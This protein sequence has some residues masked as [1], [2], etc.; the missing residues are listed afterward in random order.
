MKELNFHGGKSAN[1]SASV[2]ELSNNN[3]LRQGIFK[4]VFAHETDPDKIADK[5]F[6]LV[7]SHSHSG[8]FFQSNDYRFIVDLAFSTGNI[9]LW[10]HFMALHR[11]YQAEHRP[12]ELRRHMRTQAR[13]KPEFMR[14]WVKRNRST[15]NNYNLNNYRIRRSKQLK[16]KDKKQAENRRKNLKYIKENQEVVRDGTHWGF[17]E[18]FAQSLLFNPDQIEAQFGDITLVRTALRNCLNFIEPEIPSLKELAELECDSKHKHVETILYA[19]C[20]ETLKNHGNLENVKPFMLAALLTNLDMHYRAVSNEDRT[21]LKTEVERLLFTTVKEVENF[22]NEYIEPQLSIVGCK[23][24]QVSW[25]RYQEIF[26]PFQKTLPIEWLK[27]FKNLSLHTQGELV[28]MAAQ[29]GNHRELEEIIDIRCAEIMSDYPEKTDNEEI[30]NLRDFWLI[31]AFYFLPNI[32]DTYWNWL[33]KD[34]NTIFTL[35]GKTGRFGGSDPNWPTLSAQK[36]EAI[37]DA[38]IDVWSKVELPSTYGTDSPAEER[39]YRF[40]SDVIW[41]IGEDD[42]DNSLPALDRL[43]SDTRFTSFELD[44]RSI[45]ATVVREKA[46]QNFSPP[47]SR[48]IVAML[49]TGE[50]ASVEGLRALLLEEFRDYQADLDGSDT[51]SKDIFYENNKHLG[52]VPATQRIA[53]RMRLRLEDKSITVTL[54]HQLKDAKRCDFTC[55]KAIGGKRKLLVIEVKGQWHSELYTAASK[56]LYDR[57]AIHPNAEQQGI[58]LV[59]WFGPDKKVAGKK[60][61]KLKTA[62]DLKFSIENKMPVELRGVID[63]F[64]LDLSLAK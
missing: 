1:E 21:A 51:T 23:H 32:S 33:K 24:P 49:D 42:P 18:V 54:E 53:D 35:D 12:N 44:L 50:I 16:K 59:L 37:L 14:E 60:N 6:N 28:E 3:K 56:Q 2:R 63:I 30:E 40:L 64:V 17:L 7:D 36:I 31:N 20:L 41:K 57:Y 46:L 9:A 62:D 15:K 39:A 48:E 10:S 58:Y 43:I 27:R 19:A 13:Q 47:S 29:Y 8:L 4:L 25:L 11:Y 45:R 34:K 55:S 38:Y 22:I 5:H 52:E 26:K 61:T